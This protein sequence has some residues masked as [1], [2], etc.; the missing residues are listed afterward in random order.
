MEALRCFRQTPALPFL[1]NLSPDRCGRGAQTGSVA[2]GAAGNTLALGAGCE[3]GKASPVQVPTSTPQPEAACTSSRGSSSPSKHGPV[4]PVWWQG[5]PR[6][7]P[8]PKRQEGPGVGTVRL[9]KKCSW[10]A[11]CPIS[12]FASKINLPLRQVNLRR[13]L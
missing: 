11:V 2:A 13:N 3:V 9:A 8:S 4:S 6:T 7:T 10:K 5:A 12:L 1:K